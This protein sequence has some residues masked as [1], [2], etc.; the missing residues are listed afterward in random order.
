MSRFA[1]FVPCV[2]RFVSC[3]PFVPFVS[4]LCHLC[5]V[6]AGIKIVL[7]SLRLISTRCVASFLFHFGFFCS[8][9]VKTRKFCS[10]NKLLSPPSDGGFLGG[11][12]A[13][14]GE[15]LEVVG[16]WGGNAMLLLSRFVKG[17]L[18]A[19]WA[20]LCWPSL[21]RSVRPLLHL[22]HPRHSR[23]WGTMVGSPKPL[24]GKIVDAA[25]LLSAEDCLHHC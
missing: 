25:S 7:Q 10:S 11:E 6:C 4:N 18:G 15:I 23:W 13:V 9:S 8:P 14:P 19:W 12:E 17:S 21:A 16:E 1:P 20:S 22:T 5:A 24:G 2:S 3:V